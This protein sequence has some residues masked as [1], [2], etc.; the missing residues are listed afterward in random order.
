MLQEH[1]PTALIANWSLWIPAQ[2]INFRFVPGKFQVLFSNVVALAWNVYL[3][4]MSHAAET[5]RP[6]SLQ[7]EKVKH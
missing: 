2:V 5:E 1:V 3:S 6:I 7:K 4:F